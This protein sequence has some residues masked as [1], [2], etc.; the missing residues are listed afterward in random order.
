MVGSP[1]VPGGASVDGTT[2]EELL[3]EGAGTMVDE[4]PIIALDEEIPRASLP[5]P[6]FVKIDIERWEI[7]A[8]R[9]AR[10]GATSAAFLEMSGE[11]KRKVAEIV[12]SLGHQLPACPT[13]RK[14][15]AIAPENATVA[16]AGH[17]YC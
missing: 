6:D 16:M 4:I 8:L 3:R 5:T 13:H 12:A 17:L 9:G 10:R 1:L 15:K 7:E 11:K 14:G 2:V